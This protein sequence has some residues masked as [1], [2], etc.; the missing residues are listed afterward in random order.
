V[1]AA[2]VIDKLGSKA[3]AAAVLSAVPELWDTA[4]LGECL[5][6][7][8][9]FNPEPVNFLVNN[10]GIAYKLLPLTRQSRGDRD[11]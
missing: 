7:T 2:Q 9:I 5:S 4:V 6:R 11:P 10:P 8:Q 3:S 1:T